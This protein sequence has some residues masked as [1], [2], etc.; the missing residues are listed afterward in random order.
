MTSMRMRLVSCC[1]TSQTCVSHFA[2]FCC[3]VFGDSRLFAHASFHLH[4]SFSSVRG[5]GRGDDVHAN[6][7]CVLLRYF[8]NAAGCSVKPLLPLLVS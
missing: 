5:M 6:A 3:G 8:S 7:A 2:S 1:V 4:L